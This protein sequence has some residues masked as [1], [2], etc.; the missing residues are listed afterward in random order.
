LAAKYENADTSRPETA[1]FR[2]IFEESA[3][4]PARY[5]AS[6]GWQSS[7]LLAHLNTRAGNNTADQ[8]RPAPDRDGNQTAAKPAGAPSLIGTA[9]A[10]GPLAGPPIAPQ[11][12]VPLSMPTPTLDQFGRD[13]SKLGLRP[14]ENLVKTIFM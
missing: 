4:L 11:P 2:A 9:H 8:T 14:L 3:S 1:L 7:A 12:E 13:L 5:L 10:S 6:I